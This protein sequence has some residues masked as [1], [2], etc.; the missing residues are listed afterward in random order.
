VGHTNHGSI[1]NCYSTGYVSGTTSIGGLL[2]YNYDGCTIMASFWDTQTS[3]QLNSAGGTG[4]ATAEMKTVSTFTSAGWDFSSSQGDWWI[5][6]N[7]YPHLFWEHYW[8][9]GTADDPYQIWTHQQMNAI[10]S[11]PSDWNKHFKLMADIDMS[12]HTGTQ[13]NIIGNETKPFIGSFDG[14]HHKILNLTYSSMEWSNIGL[15]G[16]VVGGQIKNLGLENVNITGRN[17]V[18]GL[19]GANGGTLMSCYTTG[20]VS[21]S[22][23]IGGLVGSSWGTLSSCYANCTVSGSSMDVFAIGGLVGSNEGTITTCY[24]ASSVSG[25][26]SDLAMSDVI[27]GLAGYNNGTIETCY[28]T[29]YVLNGYTVGGLVGGNNGTITSC[30]TTDYV[31]NCNICGGLA[32]YNDGDFAACFW[33][34]DINEWFTQT[35]T[36]GVGGGSSAGVTGKTTDEMKTISTFTAAMWDF[37]NERANGTNDYWRMCVDGVDYPRLNWQLPAGDFACP[38]GVNFVDFAYFAGRWQESDC[39]VSNNYCGGADMHTSGTV[40]MQDLTIFAGQWLTGI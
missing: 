17:Y 13:Y 23:Y 28:A 15:F 33:D 18:G 24:A 8:G 27:G 1:T 30:Y 9:S 19:V 35:G 22:W 4:M 32:G 29:G 21:G 20:S 39:T 14:N 34:T 31:S 36:T 37:T 12:A 5:P 2:G 11:I 16:M 26:D 6:G 7:D 25:S 10:G 38:N 40:D 3:G